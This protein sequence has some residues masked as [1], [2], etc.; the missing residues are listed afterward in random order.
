MP[1]NALPNLPV[2]AETTEENAK[3]WLRII[4]FHESGIII[5]P[6]DD[7]EY[8]IPQAIENKDYLK[9][10]LGP[11]YRKYI[12][13]SIPLD[14][15]KLETAIKKSLIKALQDKKLAVPPRTDKM[16]PIQLAD[17]IANQGFDIGL[18]IYRIGKMIKKIDFKAFLELEY[19]LEQSK[20]V[21]VL[22]FS[23]DDLTHPQYQILTDK[24]SVLFDHVLFYPFYN[25][26]D[27]TQFVR[28]YQNQWRVKLPTSLVE[29]AIRLS[30]GYLWLLH[31]ML[32]N[33]RDGFENSFDNITSDELLIS[34]LTI[35]YNKFKKEEKTLL[36][37]A[38]LG[39]L[40]ESDKTSHEFKYLEKIGVFKTNAGK[41]EISPPILTT[42]IRRE[43]EINT[44]KVEDGKIVKK[45]TDITSEFTPNE[46]KM[47]VSLVKKEKQTVKRETVAKVLWGKDWPDRYSDW[48][49][50]RI[51]SR[52][53]KKLKKLS[54]D[55]ALIRTHKKKGF[56]YG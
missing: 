21:S 8:R 29:K 42:I 33:I 37:K 1:K 12:L 51:A 36:E 3:K 22:L 23:E 44:L 26:K 5:Q 40:G 49:I 27:C 55:P 48:A 53:R 17:F 15:Y 10:F 35:V 38:V 31:H 54:I 6:Q 14:D 9:R 47:L 28:Y 45:G 25:Q 39:L 50:D 19:L 30:G 2:S 16:S 7:A 18:F 20:N 4:R 34:K 43:L 24:C 32:R 56:S 52:L 41:T 13:C 11:Y 46:T